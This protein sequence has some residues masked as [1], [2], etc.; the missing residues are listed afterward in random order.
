MRCSRLALVI[1]VGVSFGLLSGCATTARMPGFVPFLGKS[2]ARTAAKNGAKI[3]TRSLAMEMRLTPLPVKLS[4]TRYLGVRITLENISKRSV[5]LEFPTSQRIDILIINEAG[6][7]I[8]R[9]SD[10]HPFE[11]TIGRI[12]I[13]PGERVEYASNVSTRDLKPGRSYT[14]TGLFPSFDD[15]KIEQAIVPEN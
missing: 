14:V 13:N 4:E 8:S 7:L 1:A 11:S 2:K 12:G 5:Q 3:R 15:L 10:D 6:A 9:W